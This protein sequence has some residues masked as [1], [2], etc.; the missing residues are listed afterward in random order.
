M[1]DQVIRLAILLA[2]VAVVVGVMSKLMQGPIVF[3]AR[4]WHM[5]AQT[6]LLFAIAWGVGLSVS[7]ASSGS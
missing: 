1:K 2:V 7:K 5:F 4:S 6:S 3:S